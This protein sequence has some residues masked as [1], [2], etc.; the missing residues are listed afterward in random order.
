MQD[1]ANQMVIFGGFEG[2]ERDRHTEYK[3]QQAGTEGCFIY[4]QDSADVAAPT[5]AASSVSPAR[6]QTQQLQRD[7]SRQEV[8]QQ[9][10]DISEP[11]DAARRCGYPA[12]CSSD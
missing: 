2:F 10:A 11:F 4:A 3:S 12:D 8:L 7:G 9:L 5:P 1:S 6:Y